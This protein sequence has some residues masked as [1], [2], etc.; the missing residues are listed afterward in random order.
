MKKRK[1][2]LKVLIISLI[3]VYAV[4]LVGN[5]FT[6]L[7]INT[8]WYEAIKPSITPPNWV[9]M[10]AWNILFLLIALSLYFAWVSAKN[11]DQKKRIGMVFGANLLI[12]L[13]WSFIFFGLKQ[14]TFAF[15]ELIVLWFSIL[16]MIFIAGKV[17]RLS[18][19]LL[20]PYLLWISFAGVLNLLIIL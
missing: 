16:L 10:I 20:I 1:I 4:G 3:I 18:A 5:F 2:N 8:I 7:N 12:N 13:L 17:N 15:Y 6:S 19:Y 9:F 14:P 11:K